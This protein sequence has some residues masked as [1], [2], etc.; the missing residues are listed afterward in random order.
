MSVPSGY[1]YILFIFIKGNLQCCHLCNDSDFETQKFI[2]RQL[3]EA[4]VRNWTSGGTVKVHNILS[5]KS[6]QLSRP[7]WNLVGLD[8]PTTTHWLRQ[9]FIDNYDNNVCPQVLWPARAVSWRPITNLPQEKKK[10]V[11]EG[12]SLSDFITGEAS[13]YGYILC[14]PSACYALHLVYWK[15]WT[16]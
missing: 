2:L 6:K 16:V 13:T 8:C 5:I 14:Y 3:W 1:T 7:K 12:P 10:K 4:V 11:A 15:P 9:A